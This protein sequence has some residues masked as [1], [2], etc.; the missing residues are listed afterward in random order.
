VQAAIATG[1]IDASTIPHCLAVPRPA[2]KLDLAQINMHGADADQIR[3]MLLDGIDIDASG[4][5]FVPAILDAPLEQA[6]AEEVADSTPWEQ[7]A[8]QL[9]EPQW[10]LLM[11]L[12]EGN[13]TSQ[14]LTELSRE[15]KVMPDELLD[16]LNDLAIDTVGD[17][18]FD[19]GLAPYH[20]YDEY[21]DDVVAIIEARKQEKG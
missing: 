14:L 13:A 10:K 12:A 7:L 16:Q 8:R 2:I 4:I 20:L 21:Q 17:A 1:Q 3:E 9:S 11:A 6:E 19:S 5:E 15:S 18:L